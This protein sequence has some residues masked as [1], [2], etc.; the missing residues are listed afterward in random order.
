MEVYSNGESG[1][2]C[3]FEKLEKSF[4]G[5]AFIRS[6]WH[7]FGSI[8]YHKSF[9]SGLF[10]FFFEKGHGVHLSSDSIAKGSDFFALNR[11]DNQVVDRLF[12]FAL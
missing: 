11:E 12:E 4:K 3:D 5:F 7:Q 6:H 8:Y 9:V 1:V 10:H 2:D